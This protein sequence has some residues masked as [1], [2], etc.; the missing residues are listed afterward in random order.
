M[1]LKYK[2]GGRIDIH[3]L[4]KGVPTVHGPIIDGE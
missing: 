2:I 4:N 1:P 3:G